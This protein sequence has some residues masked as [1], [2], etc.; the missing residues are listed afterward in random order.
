MMV[1]QRTPKYRG[2]Y[3]K[4][5]VL[6]GGVFAVAL[7]A[8]L[9]LVYYA[10]TWEFH[11]VACPQCVS[12]P[13][14]QAAGGTQA[15]LVYLASGD[16]WR[17]RRNALL[18]VVGGS[19]V[20]LG[21][22]VFYAV[23]RLVI[24]PLK[25]I[26]QGVVAIAQGNLDHRLR[27][28]TGDEL[29]LLA[30]EFNSMAQKLC[31]SYDDIANERS[32]LIASIEH[33]RDAI[34]IS[35]AE[36]RIIRVNSALERLTGRSRA[37]LIGQNCHALMGMR[38]VDGLPMCEFAC[39]LLNASAPHGAIEGYM[40]SATGKDAWVEIGY[41]YVTNAAGQVT[42]VVHIVHD[43][44]ERKE[45][46]RLKD[47]FVS[48]ISHELRTPLHHIKG[49]ATTLLQTDVTWDK[50]TQRDFLESI[51]NE[52][53]RLATL[54]EKI[55]HLS[56]LEAGAAPLVREWCAMTDW[57]N[58]ALARRRISAVRPRLQLHLPAT[59]PTL[60]IDNRQL[61][62]VLI[63]LI[64]NAAKYSAAETPIVL[65]AEVAEQEVIF[66]VADQGRGIPQAHLKSI[67]ARF[68]RVD[69]QEHRIASTGLGLAI[70]KRIVEAHGGR[71][72]V[73]SALGVGSCFYFT[74]PVYSN[75]NPEGEQGHEE[76]ARVVG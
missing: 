1:D 36:Q 35:D 31:E 47:E 17:Q 50:A 14:S 21:L 57:V 30:Q 64:E 53:D 22:I 76:V 51:N 2:L 15:D 6:V 71:I 56:R 9:G 25:T 75:R 68:Y 67:F 10:E 34:W 72:W 3:A 29:A 39:P 38:T 74:L 18:R 27:V 54:V 65:Q 66:S 69:E 73:E 43:L 62:T 16:L 20:V 13:N 4:I 48:M 8:I 24:R 33:S 32:K 19:L 49:F 42:E 44:T 37:T 60:F 58:G 40:P 55:L 52:A 59:L 28:D 23:Q 70:C 46:E 41:G 7:L 26:H 12:T 11:Y 63:N 61:E 5:M 45:L